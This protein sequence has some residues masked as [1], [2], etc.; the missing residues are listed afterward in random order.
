MAAEYIIG[1][2]SSMV[3]EVTTLPFDVI[4]V[5]LQLDKGLTFYETCRNLIKEGGISALFIG[6]QP[7][8]LRQVFYGTIRYGLY[9]PVKKFLSGGH[10]DYDNLVL[11]HLL[12]GISLE[13]NK[14][15]IFRSIYINRFRNRLLYRCSSG[16]H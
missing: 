16:W 12:A 11:N 6:L 7:A 5:R 15:H 2:V 3:A 8:L 14:D 4:K 9:P 10:F 1:G 13:L